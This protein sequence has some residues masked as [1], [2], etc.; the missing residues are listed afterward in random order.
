[1]IK[2]ILPPF[3]KFTIGLMVILFLSAIYLYAFPAPTLLYAGMV[4]LHAGAGLVAI[5]CLIRFCLR[6]LRETNLTVR[7][8][9]IAMALG[10]IVGGMLV[11]IGTTRQ[12]LKWLY[13]HIGLCVAGAI[14][15]AADGTASRMS[16][17][18]TIATAKI[19]ATAIAT[20]AVCV[21]ALAYSAWS[22]REGRW[23]ASHV[24]QNP[25]I[26]PANMNDEGDGP[27]GPFFPSSAQVI[28]GG[29]IPSKF[30]MESDSCKRCH[31]DIYNEWN[32]SV[33]HFSS[34][35]NQWY[36]K[37]IEYMQ[38]VVG[39][40][41]SKW[42]GGCHDPAVLYSGLMDTPI[43]QIVHRPEAQA[44]L[45]CMMCHSIA[46][47]KSTM[48]QGDF[49]LEYP[50][51]H[52]LAA[53][54]NP[55]IRSIHDFMTYLNPE[56]HRRTFLKPFMRTQ[57]AEF[58]SS[59]HKVHLDGPVN[60][61]RWSRGFDEYDNWQASGVS[62]FGA[63]SFY[64]P[65]KSQ[66]CADCHMPLQKSEDAGNIKGM[67]HSHRFPAAN[68]AVPTA[69]QDAEQ[70]KITED[71]LKNKILSVDIFA[72]SAAQPERKTSAIA[73]QPDMSTTFGVGEEAE[74]KIV[75]KDEGPVA[76][77]TA[78]LNSVQ[79]VVRRGDTVQVDVVVRTRTIG[80]FFPG[81][82]VDAYDT[83]LELKG[84]DDRG[85]V[86]FWS[87]KIEDDGKG[88]V[89]K[90]A[91][92]YRALQVDAHGHPINKRNAW[93]TRA[94]VY[95]RL[96]PP[97]A[98]DTAHFRVA[99]PKTAGNQIKLHARL[100]YRK[101]AWYNTQ[102][103]FAGVSGPS[104]GGTVSPEYDDRPMAFTGSTAEVSGA[105][106]KI[107]DLPVVALAEDEV[108]LQVVD[109]NAPVPAPKVELNAK[110]WQRWN[111]YGIGLFLQGDLKAAQ[112][113][114]QKVTELDPKNPDGWVNIG[115]AAVQEG[116]M[117]RARTVLKRALEIN[118]KL[119]RTN[120]FYAKVLRNDGDYDGAAER[121]R[122][123]LSQYPRDRVALNDLG[124]I[125]F[126]Q[127]K[128][129]DAIQQLQ[130]VLAIDPEDLQANYNLM[131]C[132]N[133]LR[134]QK[135]SHDFE[136][137]YLRFKADESAQ[138]LTGPYRLLNAE[139]NQERQAIHEHGSV[140][141]GPEHKET[142]VSARIRTK[143][144]PAQARQNALKSGDEAQNK[145]SQASNV[146]GSGTSTVRQNKQR[147]RGR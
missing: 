14:L 69:N 114:F 62:G 74:S 63:R 131:L 108:T 116:D 113:A 112:A 82:T 21:F 84:T 17:K 115:R 41:P 128:Y 55:V 60:H 50:K 7:V 147:E 75:A 92:F 57:T 36:R 126:L 81:G 134:D 105:Q 77:V 9:W 29:H 61:Y 30:F 124:R 11:Y 89:E 130:A 52:E 109:H 42:C 101:F 121:L 26:A 38:D 66:Q 54:K 120:F 47:V 99:I 64:Y 96:I 143:G 45:G 18:T 71:F 12:N 24:I 123:V 93:S 132:Y 80:H 56:P 110:E 102:F 37:S 76:P 39:T 106:K 2:K 51:L 34:F 133:G 79:P 138:A 144:K 122:M 6:Y 32:S 139:D 20:L 125:L 140:P 1:M 73:P 23:V 65:A 87:G 19:R 118:P 8:G 98:A 100:C 91:H 94:V 22:F 129:T 43:K 95:V 136:T 5:F 86:V 13:L 117:E 72:L 83:W 107:P 97:G 46:Q 49:Y 68:T 35:N 15:L 135:R 40:K 33:H 31:A 53:S 70:L 78:P 111:D 103:S 119:A 28:S 88:P 25:A 146:G 141:L 142:G 3:R 58:C 127:R 90:G 48:G 85:Q 104:K 10:G 67:I 59:C 16:R 27:K 137:R 44:G 145:V 4:L